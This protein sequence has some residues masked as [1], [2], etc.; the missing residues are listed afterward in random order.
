MDVVISMLDHHLSLTG[1]IIDR[2]ARVDP[3]TLD[4][5]ITLS[6]EGIDRDPTLRSVC[7]RLVGQ[8]EMWVGA[9]KG[10]NRRPLARGGPLQF[11]S[12]PSARALYAGG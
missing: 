11:P 3:S 4:R 9:P 7:T 2:L 12:S 6:V 1:E 5:P 8:L 10:A